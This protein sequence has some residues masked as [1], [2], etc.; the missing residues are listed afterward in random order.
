[1]SGWLLA[2]LTFINYIVLGVGALPAALPPVTASATLPPAPALRT[3][4][5]S[6]R[7]RLVVKQGTGLWRTVA[8][9]AYGIGD[10]FLGGHMACGG[11]LDSRH[12]TVAY[13][14]LHTS[15]AELHCGDQIRIRLAGSKGPGI[16]VTVTDAGP[17]V[18][19]RIFDLGPAACRALGVCGI[20]RIEWRR[21]T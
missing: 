13:R 1:L 8:S 20:P 18:G 15:R 2:V 21:V 4:L 9:S 19:A 7:P 11:R 10:G 16:L 14:Y 6:Q 12:L 17:F 5:A 3:A